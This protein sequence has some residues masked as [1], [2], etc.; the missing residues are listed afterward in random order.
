VSQQLFDNAALTVNYVGNVARDQMGYR[1]YNEPVN[2]VRPGV[3]A[4]DPDGVLIPSEARGANFRRVWVT[5]TGPGWDGDYKS[6]QISM[7]RRMANRWSGRLAYT[8]QRSN[9]VGLGNP[10]SRRVWLDNEL[11]NDRGRFASDRT[12]VLAM[13]GVFN[14]WQSLTVATVLSAISGAPYN[15]TIGRDANGDN[16]SNNDRPIQGIDDLLVPIQSAV[17]SAGRAVING[18]DGPGSL[19]LDVSFRYSI[20][21]AAGL[22]SL[23]LFY[24]IFNLTNRVNLVTPTGNRRSSNF[25]VSTAAQ[26]PRQMQ[27]GVRVRF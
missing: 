1:D 22:E 13:S 17:D 5:E 19:L 2:G 14:V 24:D 9:Y 11:R 6:L 21:L 8:L 18:L 7:V 15:E 23:D 27:F 12:H 3:E 20:P 25:G 10:D 16:E 26:F 4:F